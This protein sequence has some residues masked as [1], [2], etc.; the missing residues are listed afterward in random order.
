MYMTYNIV[1]LSIF[2]VFI[3]M[4]GGCNTILFMHSGGGRGGGSIT[5]RATKKLMQSP[6]PTQIT[7]IFT[8]VIYIAA[9]V[10]HIAKLI[11]VKNY[12]HV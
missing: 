11:S 8:L 2:T 6:D 9:N 12:I 7:S 5:T 4:C 3:I 1:Y 10:R